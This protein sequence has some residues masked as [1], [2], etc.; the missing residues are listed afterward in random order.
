MYLRTCACKITLDPFYGRTGT[1][2][3]KSC[4]VSSP[5][6]AQCLGEPQKNHPLVLVYSSPQL[7]SLMVSGTFRLVFRDSFLA[8]P[9][10]PPPPPPRPTPLPGPLFSKFSVAGSD[11]P[12]PPPPTLLGLRTRM[13]SGVR[14]PSPAQA[15]DKRRK[16]SI[17]GL[18]EDVNNFR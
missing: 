1:P 14:S 10:P 17:T 3:T 11:W 2:Y 13:F 15:T 5:F 6:K 8:R 9:L 4:F 7:S 18:S 16:S 12:P